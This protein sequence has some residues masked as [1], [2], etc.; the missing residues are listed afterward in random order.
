MLHRRV[1]KEKFK[2]QSPWQTFF[3]AFDKSTDTSKDS[4]T[5][6]K[7]EMS[8]VGEMGRIITIHAFKM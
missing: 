7:T 3:N 4:P 5:N 6:R 1:E 2:N 8:R